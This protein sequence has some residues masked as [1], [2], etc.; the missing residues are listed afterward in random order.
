MRI[1]SLAGAWE[2]RQAGT[3]EWL[4]AVVPGGVHTDLL[5]QGRI[6]DPFVADNEKRVQWVAESDWMYRYRFSCSA[7]LLSQDKILLV[8]D[9]LDT[10]AT[11]T[12]NGQELGHTDNMFRQYRWEVK[13]YLHPEDAVAEGT[14]NELTIH[15]A[16]PVRYIA[17]KQALRPLFGVSQAIPGGPYLRKAPCQFGWDWGPQLPPIGIWKD[18]RLEGYS[19]AYIEE[20]HLRQH[21]TDEAVTVEAH[22][23]VQDWNPDPVTAF[24]HLTAPDGDVFQAE[25]LVD[26]DGEATVK[27]LINHPRYWWPNGYGDQPLYQVEVG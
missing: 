23:V 10:L 3:K 14:S 16:S 5:A 8:C 27:V 24:M 4:P 2:F 7:E 15:F 25:S 22:L 11:V 12:L 21:H 18:I 1:Q 20:V 13:H 6:P 26:A 9:G 19:G 17:S